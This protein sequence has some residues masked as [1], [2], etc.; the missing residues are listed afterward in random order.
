MV[1][2][3]PKINP[4]YL[5]RIAIGLSF[6]VLL[7]ANMKLAY[8]WFILFVPSWLMTA[9]FSTSKKSS[10][11][12]MVLS[13]MLCLILLI[14]I[15]LL[16]K[17]LNLNHILIVLVYT[18]IFL[19]VIITLYNLRFKDRIKIKS[20]KNDIE[21]ELSILFSI[22]TII[23]ASIISSFILRT[24]LPDETGYAFNTQLFK[25]ENFVL[26]SRFP[27]TS[28]Y[29]KF[30]GSKLLWISYL[31]AV[32]IL[33]QLPENDL[34]LSNLIFLA[35]LYFLATLFLKEIFNVRETFQLLLMSFFACLTPIV[36]LWSTRILPDLF[37][38]YIVLGAIYFMLK[39]VDFENNISFSSKYFTL[40]L[41]FIL[42]QIILVRTNI[43]T[44][45]L[46]LFAVLTHIHLQVRRCNM[47]VGVVLLL[48]KLMLLL[49]LIYI[50]IDICYAISVYVLRNLE[51]TIFF[52]RFLILDISLVESLIGLITNLSARQ[53]LTSYTFYELFDRLNFAL[54]PELNGLLAAAVPLL[55]VSPAFYGIKYR[56]ALL[57]VTISSISFWIYFSYL[58]TLANFQDISRYCLH[59][60]ILFIMTAFSEIYHTFTRTW[61]V[62]IL[63]KPSIPLII[64]YIVTAN[65]G[66]TSFF[67]LMERYSSSNIVLLTEYLVL[68]VL[69][70]MFS[71]F[72]KR[73]MYHFK[74]LF[75][76][77]ILSICILYSVFFSKIS[78]EKSKSG[79]VMFT[80][81]D[82]ILMNLA[83]VIENLYNNSSS[84]FIISNFHLYI[85]N[86]FD[87]KRFTILPM[88]LSIDEF[89]VLLEI[90]PDKSLIVITNDPYL[91][92]YTYINR[93]INPF[94]DFKEIFFPNGVK[95]NRL[96]LFEWEG[97]KYVI[98]EKKTTM[99]INEVLGA[100]HDISLSWIQ[101]SRSCFLNYSGFSNGTIILS[102]LK[103]SKIVNLNTRFQV[104]PYIDPELN[105]YISPNVCYMVQLIDS[106]GS[107]FYGFSIIMLSE[108]LLIIG[109][110]AVL[111]ILLLI[112][113]ITGLA[114][115]V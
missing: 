23:I 6:V 50:T 58:T 75:V 19:I 107:K 67:W 39:A 52:R 88:P 100:L 22:I 102:T 8:L 17:L 13:N 83:S 104:F 55:P 109:I 78:I 2:I 74:T 62:F 33:L 18:F 26:S 34:Y 30:F 82:I 95:L 60:Y 1:I 16:S 29:H 28:Q 45:T 49:S 98:F 86:Y 105:I 90:I 31:C 24:Y 12:V 10:L 41:F 4:F 80:A 3:K 77:L 115:K 38:S 61:N 54:A 15:I 79:S 76:T 73:K 92:Y 112:F 93:N 20:L 114:R 63:F 110:F 42:T 85:R 35:F 5:I 53:P 97:F 11:E 103:F 108:L 14:L 87:V 47:K 44:T 91:S 27:L 9:L 37:D 96:Y 51:L 106:H 66:G 113:A 36:F 70:L 89:Y 81:R 69:F 64:N 111:Y 57:S 48:S 46:L 43:I 25:S 7:A 21:L 71:V 56:R 65:S 99:K 72:K 94:I 68:I 101:T 32:K 59:L 40:G 84:V